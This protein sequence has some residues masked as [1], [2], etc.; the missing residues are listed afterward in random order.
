MAEFEY[1]PFDS[2][3]DLEYVCPNCKHHNKE[4]IDVPRPDWNS[5][6]HSRSIN[7]DEIEVTC[8]QC[9][10]SYS[11]IMATGISGG[12]GFMKDVDEDLNVR[13]VDDIS[14]ESEETRTREE[15]IDSLDTVI[16]PRDIIAFNEMRSCADLEV[17]RDR[18]LSPSV[19]VTIHRLSLESLNQSSANSCK[20]L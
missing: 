18:Y 14:E 7:S 11:V 2:K 15:E 6:S 4:Q 19:P 20:S 9:G 8:Q 17:T 12:E 3:L 1:S 5:D 10:K 16:P 13:P